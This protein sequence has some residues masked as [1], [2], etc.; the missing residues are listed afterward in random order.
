MSAAV[1]PERLWTGTGSR[2]I[3]LRF[4]D[5][6]TGKVAADLQV[7]VLDP[8]VDGLI[9]NLV[10]NGHEPGIVDLAGRTLHKLLG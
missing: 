7:R 1:N 3:A 6:R 4:E 9:V 5:G 2:A 8:G 10:T